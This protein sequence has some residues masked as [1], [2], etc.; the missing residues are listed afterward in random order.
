LAETLSPFLDRPVVNDTNAAGKYKASIDLPLSA[1]I[2]MMQ[3]Q[4]RTSGFDFG[5]GGGPGRGGFDGG[6][7]G[8]FDGG[9]RGAQFAQCIDPSMFSSDSPDAS[10]GPLIEAIQK[11]GLKL[12]KRKE[13]FDTIIVD[14]IDKE[15]TEN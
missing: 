5:R 12:D 4:A 9:G 11:L 1:M 8:G 7:R 6:G 15:P 14:H 3:N 10:N 2:G 13:P